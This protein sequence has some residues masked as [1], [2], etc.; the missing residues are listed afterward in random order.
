MSR[1][2]QKVMHK[3][4]PPELSGVFAA[5]PTPFRPDGSADAEKLHRILD[6]LLTK[7]VRGFCLGGVTGEYAALGVEERLLLFQDAAR[8]IAGRAVLIAGVG[9]E[10]SGQVRRLGQ[11]AAEIGAVAA[12]LPP[13]FFFHHNSGDVLDFLLSVAPEIPVPVIFYNIPQFASAVS[14][15]DI[16][17]FIGSAPNAVGIKDSSGDKSN[18]PLL[19]QAKTAMPM[20]FLTGSDDL[21]LEALENGADGAISGLAA[22]CPELHLALYQAFRT[23]QTEEARRLQHLLDA[24][25]AR[26]GEFP[27]PWA[28]KLALESRG[29]DIGSPSLPRGK[30]QIARAD[31]FKAWFQEWI[32]KC[33]TACARM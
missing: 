18:L 30:R 31:A 32:M 11:G 5:V 19:R 27:P 24:L 3:S 23:G 14:M 16:L 17:H 13:P 1:N 12:L 4:V 6:F 10:H 29:L 21:F 20:A 28:I 2:V 15:D 25:I 7:G 9:A 22:A 8:Y 33:D 26:I